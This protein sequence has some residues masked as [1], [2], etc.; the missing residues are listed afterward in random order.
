[1]VISNDKAKS[2]MD[3]IRAA[4]AEW[5]R[6]AN[7]VE[8]DKSK[9]IYLSLDTALMMVADETTNDYLDPD[10]LVTLGNIIESLELWKK[11]IV[12]RQRRHPETA[13]LFRA[14]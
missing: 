13:G 7:G 11:I 9:L 5:E 12:R 3:K 14:P 2:V 10:L 1:M 4:R 8:C 6:I